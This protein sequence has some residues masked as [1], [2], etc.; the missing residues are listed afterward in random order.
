MDLLTLSLFILGFIFLT[1]GADVLVRGAAQL[2]G[3]L[4]MSPLLVGLTVVAFG[5]S[6]PELAISLQSAFNGQPDIALGNVVGSNI[7]NILLI[8]GIASLITPLV[9]SRQMIRVDIPLMIGASFLLL[10]FA[11]T[12]NEIS[13]L[14]GGIMLVGIVSYLSFS[15]FKSRQTPP[16]TQAEIVQE[17]GVTND[18][19]KTPWSKNLLLIIIGLVLLVIGSQWLVNGAIAI[20]RLFGL[21]ELIIGLTI[22]AIGTSLPEI[23][24]SVAACLRGHQDIVVGN[25]IGSNL[26]NIL[27][28]LG[29]TA[30]ASSTGIH[31]S[32]SALF[33]DIPVMI[34]V[35]LAS[36]PIFFTGHLIERWEGG[37]FLAYYS[38]YLLYLVF[39]ATEHALLPAYSA[40]MLWFVIPLTMLTLLIFVK[41]TWRKD[42]Q[43]N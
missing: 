10:F 21:S 41:R 30:T 42:I 7:A 27:L 24:A 29:A 25:V 26:F 40:I 36:L 8:L 38:A 3:S 33:F 14:E 9:V 2:A 20:A 13:R 19:D 34:A 15:I 16:E 11:S 1:Y 22:I 23:A 18:A 4:G 32:S 37:L 39:N 28:V 5:T 43:A 17:A 6:A 12:N 35:A 31:I